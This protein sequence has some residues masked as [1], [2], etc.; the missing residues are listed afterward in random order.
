MITPAL[1]GHARPGLWNS[2]V[3]LDLGGTDPQM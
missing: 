3:I 1:A 2:T